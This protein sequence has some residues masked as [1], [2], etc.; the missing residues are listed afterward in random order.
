[1]KE[2]LKTKVLLDKDSVRLLLN[3]S[4]INQLPSLNTF[5]KDSER[6]NVTSRDIEFF[7]DEVKNILLYDLG[8]FKNDIY[9]E[10]KA[11][12]DGDNLLH[13]DSGDTDSN[14]QVC[15]APNRH[16]FYIRNIATGKELHVGSTCIFNYIDIELSNET[17]EEFLKRQEKQI[18]RRRNTSAFNA[19]FPGAV[20]MVNGWLDFYNSLPLVLPSD[21]DNEFK[22]CYKKA[23]IIIKK[24]EVN[25]VTGQ[26]VDSFEKCI[27][28]YENVKDKM[29][30]YVDVNKN[31]RFAYTK[32]M[33]EWLI[34]RKKVKVHQTLQKTCY[35]SKK[36]FSQIYE[37]TF[38]KQFIDEYLSIIKK[39]GIRDIE[40][41]YERGIFIFSY[42]KDKESY[43]LQCSMPS[44]LERYSNVIYDGCKTIKFDELFS[45]C[46]LNKDEA[47]Y[48][49]II[50][51]LNDKL[52][53]LPI[54]IVEFYMD[55]D[56]LV[57]KNIQTRTYKKLTL[58]GFVNN[59]SK[60][61][62]FSRNDFSGINSLSSM[63]GILLQSGGWMSEDDYNELKQQWQ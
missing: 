21:I 53:S 37:E 24:V 62:V 42:N 3:G 17:K 47:T 4:I 27:Q 39:L 29:Q 43:K 13:Y 44:F 38:I 19:R 10:W 45:I 9:G 58:D 63:V 60:Y 54:K 5:L 18:D 61:V 40:S 30:Q 6:Q 56:I 2:R 15:H 22:S 25:A 36:E 28:S 46:K 50:E 52:K 14:C 1:M 34:M 23:N 57:I 49:F 26:A 8:R 20:A 59:Y 12:R 16:L 11:M 35:V 48:G 41:N 7:D 33:Y 32:K 55:F 51:K 31:N